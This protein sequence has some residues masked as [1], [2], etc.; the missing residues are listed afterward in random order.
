MGKQVATHVKIFATYR[1][2]F[3][4]LTI[5][6]SGWQKTT[7]WLAARQLAGCDRHAEATSCQLLPS[8]RLPPR[9]RQSSRGPSPRGA[10]STGTSSSASSSPGWCT[11]YRLGHS[12][13]QHSVL[14]II[15]YS[16]SSKWENYGFKSVKLTSSV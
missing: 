5:V 4:R 8:A 12:L 13:P 15:V 14:Y 16:L 11:P 6:L 1:V 3:G 7:N 10:T 9:A 2:K